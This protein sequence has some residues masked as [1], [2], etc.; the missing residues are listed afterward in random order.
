MIE[1]FFVKVKKLINLEK[2]KFVTEKGKF[3]KNYKM[4]F[5]DF[6]YYIIGNKGK[7][8]ALELYDYSKVKYKTVL[9]CVKMC[10]TKQDFSKQRQYIKPEFF[11]EANRL[12]IEDVYSSKKHPLEKFYDCFVLN[13]DGSQ[14]TIPNTAQ[15]RAEFDIDLNSLEKADTPK[16]RISVVSDAKNDFIID[17]A[18]DSLSVGEHELAYKHI[19]RIDKILDLKKAINVFDRYYVST[20]LIIQ[21]LSK[22]SYFIFR[23]KSNTY[24]NE[25]NTMK[26]DDEWVNIDLYHNRKQNIKHEEI[27]AIA[28][29]LDFLNLR[30]VNIP[31]KTGEIE[32]LLTNIPD[33]MATSLELK[34]LYGE[35][36]Q[37]E[38]CYDVLKNKL[39]LENFSGKKRITIE[40]DFYSQILMY[41]MLIEYKMHCN[42]ELKENQENNNLKCEYK[43]NM[44]ILAGQL[45]T[46]LFEMFLA[47]TND[48]REEIQRE[49]LIIAKK[50]IIKVEKKSPQPRKKKTRKLKYPYNNRKNF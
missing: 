29:K 19:E 34:N 7:T 41:N 47:E 14:V 50:N 15:T 22:E 12:G 25:R 32:T 42:K 10:V 38:R 26:A 2:D 21:L 44:N 3:T 24:I 5:E 13:Y 49:V 4:P 31:L 20:E 17:S 37:V 8:S 1:S 16:A 18:I 6:I 28:D 33:E 36:W 35:R 30:I 9:E 48:E 45:K 40:Q 43:V 46:S 23:L 39:H 27:K 11:K